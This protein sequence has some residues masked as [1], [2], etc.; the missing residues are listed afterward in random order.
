MTEFNATEGGARKGSY[1]RQG[2]CVKGGSYDVLGAG[3]S[4]TGE[5]GR[6]ADTSLP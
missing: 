5:E 2:S 3:N 6:T 1:R 4:D